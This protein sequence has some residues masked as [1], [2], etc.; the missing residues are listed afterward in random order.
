MPAMHEARI[1][2]KLKRCWTSRR[3]VTR[4]AQ[5]VTC[6][7]ANGRR[8]HGKPAAIARSERPANPNVVTR[9]VTDNH[10]ARH[11]L[12]RAIIIKYLHLISN[13][14]SNYIF[15]IT[16][17]VRFS[18]P[19]SPNALYSETSAISL[20]ELRC[21]QRRYLFGRQT[22]NILQDGISMLGELLGV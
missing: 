18:S 21:A 2:P 16:N 7:D 11:V 3:D 15:S 12:W 14:N 5:G 9:W 4:R 1:A 6:H 19:S 8:A 10:D 20:H 13:F 17:G 22:K